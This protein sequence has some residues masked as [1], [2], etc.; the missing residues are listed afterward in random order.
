MGCKGHLL[1]TCGVPGQLRRPPVPGRCLWPPPSSA[2][3]YPPPPPGLGRRL[4]S[5]RCLGNETGS[6]GQSSV[7][8][9]AVGRNP[10]AFGWLWPLGPLPS[11]SWP[12]SA[13]WGAWGRRGCCAA[14]ELAAP[15]VPEPRQLGVCPTW[16][17]PGQP[18]VAGSWSWW[19]PAATAVPE[20]C[21]TIHIFLAVPSPPAS[22]VSQGSWEAP[23][24]PSWER[25]EGVTLLCPSS[26]P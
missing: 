22:P 25:G 2:Q 6:R 21:T 9:P 13:S 11:G 23:C 4:L 3:G 5:G 16:D 18:W 19:G 20:G 17:P 10:A 8:V 7:R 14:A 12:K 26:P 1:S 15:P 24:I